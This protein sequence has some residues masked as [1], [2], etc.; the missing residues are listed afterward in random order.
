MQN[1][2]PLM[3]AWVYTTGNLVG[4]NG[5][6]SEHV[7]LQIVNLMGFNSIEEFNHKMSEYKRGEIPRD[8][9]EQIIRIFDTTSQDLDPDDPSRTIRISD[10]IVDALNEV[11]ELE[12]PFV[13]AGGANASDIQIFAMSFEPANSYVSISLRIGISKE[14][15]LQ[16]AK[17]ELAGICAD[18]T[19]KIIPVSTEEVFDNYH[20]LELDCE[21]EEYLDAWLAECRESIRDWL[22]NQGADGALADDNEFI[23]EL[24]QQMLYLG[25]GLSVTTKEF[26]EQDGSLCYF[27]IEGEE[28]LGLEDEEE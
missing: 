23:A 7:A 25:E 22:H 4:E 12:N 19:K 17:P 9:Q 10:G 21:Y 14:R 26:S 2:Q 24:G 15:F 18:I 8:L 6:P 27:W 3:D 11:L 28:E 16:P 5:E 1:K 20:K 13:C